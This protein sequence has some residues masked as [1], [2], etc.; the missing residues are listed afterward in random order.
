MGIKNKYVF[1][2][3]LLCLVSLCAVLFTVICNGSSKQREKAPLIVTSFY[4]VYIAA[5]NVIGDCEEVKLQNL[6]E[7][8]TG[9]LHDFQLTTEDMKLL[10]N[11]EIFLVNGGGMESFLTDVAKQYPH[12]TI[13][14][15]AEDAGF[16]SENAHVFMSVPRYRSQVAAITDSLCRQF[17]KQEEEFRKNALAYDKKLSELQTQQEELKTAIAGKKIV[18]LHDAFEYVANDYGLIVSYRINLDEERQTSAGFIVGDSNKRGADGVCGRI[19]WTGFSKACAERNRHWD[20]LFGL[21]DARGRQFGQLYR[22]N[23]GKYQPFKKG[24]WRIA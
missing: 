9:C 24:F 19:I 2:A 6:S 11:A 16:L 7:P 12:L 22:R 1:T 15:T 14:E 13:T 17:P 20:L 8:Q 4:P 5:A 18:S 21:L 23:A 3:V 10:S